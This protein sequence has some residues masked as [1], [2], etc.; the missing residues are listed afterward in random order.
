VL[1]PKDESMK[2]IGIL[3]TGH[4]PQEIAGD[5]GNYG[6]LFANLLSGYDFEFVRYFVVDGQ[7]PASPEDADGWL[8]TGSKFG[9]YEDYAWIRTLEQFIRDAHAAKVP[10]VGICFGHQIM[11]KALGGHVEKFKG[12]WSAGATDYR[13]LENGETQTLLAWHQDQVIRPP[14]G[15]TVIASSDFCENAALSYGDW[16]LSYQPH[17]EFSVDYYEKLA[18]F[19]KSVLPDGLYAKVQKVDKPLA[20][21]AAARSIGD[22]L[23]RK[24]P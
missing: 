8:I 18:D 1:E 11:A 10:M 21:S 23:D 3:I 13:F 14:D 17:P 4:I 15:A 7:F 5:Y 24:R 9:A 2:T 20:T 6:T 16:G 12:G 19:R 22:F